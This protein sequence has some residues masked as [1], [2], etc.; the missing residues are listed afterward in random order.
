[1]IHKGSKEVGRVSFE[2]RG[3]VHLEL[4]KESR[5]SKKRGRT[6]GEP[7]REK[8]SAQGDRLK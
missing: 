4:E 7:S 2:R 3:P 6:V 1:M 8:R 5:V